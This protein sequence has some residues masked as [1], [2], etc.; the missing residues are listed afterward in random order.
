M[1]YFTA[2]EVMQLNE[3]YHYPLKTDKEF[4]SLMKL[5]GGQPYLVRQSLYSMVKHNCNMPELETMAAQE[6]GPFGDHL[7]QFL[8][9]FEEHPEVRN[10]FRD[11]LHGR[12]CNNETHF[13]RLRAAGL[14]KGATRHEA[15]VRCELYHEYFKKHL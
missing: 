2:D 3:R 4:D 11:I 10:T 12:T 1:V 9:R 6:I 5:V 15:E 7:R 8:W 14:I 13:Q